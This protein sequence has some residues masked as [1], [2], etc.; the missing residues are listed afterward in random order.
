MSDHQIL[1]DSEFDRGAIKKYYVWQWVLICVCTVFLIP[2]LPIALLIIFMVMDRYL[3]RLSCT[4]T[5]RTLEIKKGL[6]NRVESTV[7][8]EKVT[9]LQMYQGP[10][11]RAL[12]LHGFKV[13]TA[14]QSGGAAGGSLVNMLGIVDAQAFRKAVLEQRDKVVGSGGKRSIADTGEEIDEAKVLIEIRDSMLRIEQ[15]LGERG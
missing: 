6:L 4:L 14:G 3:D 13:E 8:L 1:R 2:V 9:D 11:M 10:I 12:G 5:E 15:K 7:P